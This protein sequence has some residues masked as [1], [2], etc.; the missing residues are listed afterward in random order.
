MEPNLIVVWTPQASTATCD[1]DAFPTQEYAQQRDPKRCIGW[2]I[3]SSFISILNM[4]VMQTGMGYFYQRTSP[5]L[6]EDTT[7]D[8]I[9]HLRQSDLRT[10]HNFVLISFISQFQGLDRP[11]ACTTCHP[12]LPTRANDSIRSLHTSFTFFKHRYDLTFCKSAFLH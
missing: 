2:T 6:A 5:A 8:G 4:C 12:R 9:L 7:K 11:T 3:G 10:Y 1:L